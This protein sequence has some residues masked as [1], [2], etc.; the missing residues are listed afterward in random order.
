MVFYCSNLLLLLVYD[1]IIGARNRL[2]LIRLQASVCALLSYATVV[3]A[4]ASVSS[5]ML[6]FLLLQLLQKRS[7]T[8]NDK[9]KNQAIEDLEM[10]VKCGHQ[11]KF[12]EGE[13]EQTNGVLRLIHLNYNTCLV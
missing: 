3:V 1:N 10:A 2:H 6:L 12:L 13:K 8:A 9:E 4:A 7:Q 5:P 11:P